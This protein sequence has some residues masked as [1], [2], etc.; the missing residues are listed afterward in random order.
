LPFSTVSLARCTPVAICPTRSLFSATWPAAFPTVFTS[1]SGFGRLIEGALIEGAL[2]FGRLSFG[3]GRRLRTPWF[4]R[5]CVSAIPPA[6]PASAAPP[7]SA[8]PFAFPAIVERVDFWEPCPLR[9]RD[10][11]ELRRLCDDPP[12]RPE[13]L[14]ERFELDPFELDAFA[15]DVLAFDAFAF[16]VFDADALDEFDPLRELERLLLPLREFPLR[17]VLDERLLLVF[18][19]AIQRNLLRRLRPA[20]PRRASDS[21]TRLPATY[22]SKRRNG[23][24]LAQVGPVDG[25]TPHPVGPSAR[26]PIG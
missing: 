5:F 6:I 10:C 20:S 26:G 22:R 24:Q 4:L 15:F 14:E 3:V 17:E 11:G 12:E 1:S 2:S 7:A 21:V 16:D 25:R 19:S 9:P 23:L 8:G 13:R 18:V